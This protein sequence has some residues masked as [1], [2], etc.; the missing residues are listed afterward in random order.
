LIRTTSASQYFDTPPTN[1][2]LGLVGLFIMIT[3]LLLPAAGFAAPQETKA[4]QT[5]DPVPA[6]ERQLA[7]L[8]AKVTGQGVSASEDELL[9]Y[10]QELSDIRATASACVQNSEGLL[11][12]TGRELA[13]LVPE[14]PKKAEGAEEKPTEKRKS[15]LESPEIAAKLRELEET[16]AVLE[17][18]LAT[19]K[20]LA[21]KAEEQTNAVSALQQS[22]LAR[23]L[24][25]R[26]PNLLTVVQ[27]NLAE[28]E[29]W[30]A[31]TTRITIM[32]TGWEAVGQWHRA[33]LL[34][35]ALLAVL[36]GV[37]LRRRLRPLAAA[38]E[39]E[40]EVSAGFVHALA[41]C[42]A[43]YAPV[44]LGLGAVSLYLAGVTAH[45]G[46]LPF[47]TNLVHGLLV[48]FVAAAGIR[49]L[50]HP[51]RPARP[52][53]PLPAEVTRPLTRRIL[54][55]ALVLLA[56]W[57]LGEVRAEGLLDES[58]YLLARHVVAFFVVLNLIWIVWLLARLE[59]FRD[60]WGPRMLVTVLLLGALVAAGL[61]YAN[62]AVLLLRGVI[63]TLLVVGLT[64]LFARM[65]SEF[66]DSLDEG[67]N[68]WQQALRRSIGLKHGE[69]IPGLG[70]LRL[71]ASLALWSGFA[72]V[73][74]WVWGVSDQ[75]LVA[76]MRYLTEG[77]D[78]AGFRIVPSHLLWAILT[79]AVVLTLTRWLKGR[80]ESR[81][82]TKTRMERGAREAL[83]T[84]VGYV[85]AAV[86]VIVAL[87]VA[88]IQFTN[89]AIIAGA[90]SVGIGFGLQNVV[91]N[92]VSGLILLIERPVKTG[93]WIVVAGAEGFVRRI[94]IRS[95]QL[96]TLDR[97]DIIVPNSDLISGQ[98]TN[99][100]LHDPWGRIR[101]QV[102]VAYGSDTEKVRKILIELA[103]AHPDIIKGQ[104]GVPDPKALF[105][106]FGESSLDFEVRAVIRQIDKRFD[107]ISDL[108]FGIDK[109]FREN[110]VEI[111]FPQRDLHIKH[112]PDA[113]KRDLPGL[114]ASAD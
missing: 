73:I 69:Y 6:A 20:L 79:F 76:I 22:M 29:K 4:A 1:R 14:A 63:L 9:G 40:D 94:S 109:A 60:R 44:I 110:G 57:L 74:L 34:G 83:V 27:R 23:E 41:A 68:R 65:L 51:C 52:Y 99:W 89:L 32:S 3:V 98:V 96:Q 33:G 35:A 108:N 84:T 64:L 75:G 12:R 11:K 82:L 112:M 62:L 47:F 25:A 101:L 36:G 37:A 114:D 54:L 13:V 56:N 78:A 81:W 59:R 43:R 16:K 45:E 97:A 86:G 95:T 15:A 77:F 28:P 107:V 10:Q 42:G 58:M 90:L 46:E 17:A 21:L 72:L 91:N 30:W 8:S 93:D 106:A 38:P 5:G 80:L 19:C 105:I 67:R 50:L 111:P 88:G 48:Y 113:G 53:L 70:W 92:F 31:L 61:G 7:K 102:G 26:G 104:P 2:P 49:T 24:T 39:P 55:L 103:M 66:W 71:F 85:G 100:M 18:R 87:S